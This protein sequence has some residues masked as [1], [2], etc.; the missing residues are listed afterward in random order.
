MMM[1]SAAL[2]RAWTP[3]GCARDVLCSTSPSVTGPHPGH[4]LNPFNNIWGTNHP[5]WSAED[6]KFR[7]VLRF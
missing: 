4:A 6:A 3:P 1:D 5:M 7:F 2:L